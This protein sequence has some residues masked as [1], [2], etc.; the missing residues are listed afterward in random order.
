MAHDGLRAWGVDDASRERLLGII[1]ARCVTGRNGAT[2]QVD[3]VRRL[4][5]EGQDRTEALRQMT[6]TYVELMHSNE[7]VHTWPV[8]G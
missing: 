3:T 1:E 2:W 5:A 6:Q 4:E 7:P 8:G